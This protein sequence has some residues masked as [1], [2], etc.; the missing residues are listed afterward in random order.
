MGF[1]TAKYQR[2]E[3]LVQSSTESKISTKL[4]FKIFKDIINLSGKHLLFLHNYSL[5][6]LLAFVYPEYKW[7]SH[8]FGTASTEKWK[9]LLKGR[10]VSICG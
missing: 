6:N 2:N 7:E 1:K 8:L 9:E 4:T 10:K 5:Q 3:R